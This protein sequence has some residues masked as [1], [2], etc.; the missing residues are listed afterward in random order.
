MKNFLDAPRC[1]KLRQ[2]ASSL[3][4]ITTPNGCKLKNF[5][6]FSETS[7]SIK[8]TL[9]INMSG[10][11]NNGSSLGSNKCLYYI[12]PFLHLINTAKIRQDLQKNN[13][14]SRTTQFL[15]NW[16]PG[17]RSCLVKKLS[18]CL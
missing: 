10:D 18:L 7:S 8:P 15:F 11:S 5:E 4:Y 16:E 9:I 6:Q 14:R 17:F 12:N 2:A 3:H 1:A 13:C